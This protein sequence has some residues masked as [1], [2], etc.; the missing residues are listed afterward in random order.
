MNPKHRFV[1]FG[2]GL[3][4]GWIYHTIDIHFNNNPIAIISGIIV[5][6]ILMITTDGILKKRT[7]S[8][9]ETE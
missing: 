7:E 5:A 9:S 1:Y 2:L 6:S 3:I 8:E 4:T